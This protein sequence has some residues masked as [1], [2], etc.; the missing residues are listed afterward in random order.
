MTVMPL[1]RTLSALAAV[2]VG[3]T[4][5]V[6][7]CYQV[8]VMPGLAQLPDREFVTAFQAMDRSIVNPVFVVGTFLGGA[9]WLVA[10]T[11]VNRRSPSRFR[12][13]AAASAVYVGGVVAVTLA[14]HVPMNQRLADL[15][16]ASSTDRQVAAAR[17]KFEGPWNRLHVIR[18]GASVA[19]LVLVSLGALAR[20]DAEPDRRPTTRTPACRS[21]MGRRHGCHAD[22]ARSRSVPLIRQRVV[23]LC[24]VR[25]CLVRRSLVRRCLVRRSLVRRSPGHRTREASRMRTP[26]DIATD[27]TPRRSDEPA[28]DLLDHR[29]VHRAM[30]VDLDRLALTAASLVERPDTERM[31]VLRWYLHGVSGEIESHHHVEDEHVRP[32]LERVAGERTALLQLTDDHDRL[33]P[34]LHRAA[35][36]AALDQATPELAATLREV[37]ALLARHVADEERDVFPLIEQHVRITD[38]ERLQKRFRR[39]LKPQLLAFVVPWVVGHATAAERRDLDTFAGPVVRVLLALFEPRF[40]A[41]AELL[42][43]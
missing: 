21:W 20:D 37:S 8:A 11:I 9:V 10:A 30:T 26:S 7:L 39:N 42:F 31:D 41:R 40:R 6:M 18:T 14:G 25:R 2:T 5:G 4:A 27:A 43:S 12:R 23:R 3:I 34:L 24:C 29:V 16:V 15:V 22:A 13:L 35:S 19:A 17:S 32:L 28:P 1:A 36:L 38:H 33:D